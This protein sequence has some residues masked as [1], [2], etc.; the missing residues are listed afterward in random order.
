[1]NFNDLQ[2]KEQVDN[3]L[4]LCS[5]SQEL[6]FTALR[7]TKTSHFFSIVDIGYEVTKMSPIEQIFYIGN[8]INDIAKRNFFIELETQKIIPIPETDKFYRVDFFVSTYIERKDCGEF[9]ELTL[10]KPIVIELDGFEYHN[11]K[12]QIN[13]DYE[14][15]N[16]LKLQGYDVVRFTGSQVYK[17]VFGCL[18]KVCNMIKMADKKEVE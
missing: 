16:T 11:K 4:C 9:K 13:Y 15:E 12:K 10:K 17:N 18:D 14:R 6:I 3:F 7:N 8:Y 2:A 5:R 1:M